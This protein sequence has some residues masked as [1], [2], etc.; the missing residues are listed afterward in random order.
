MSWL[1]NILK[2]HIVKKCVH[3]KACRMCQ[4][5]LCDVTNKGIYFQISGL[6]A[7][8]DSVYL[9][10]TKRLENSSNAYNTTPRRSEKFF[11]GVS[12]PKKGT[13]R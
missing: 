13:G 8:T 2:I 1:I 9:A 7:E 3:L 11:F 4:E 6:H 5:L 10:L 12:K